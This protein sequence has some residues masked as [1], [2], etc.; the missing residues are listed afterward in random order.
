MMPPYPVTKPPKSV[1]IAILLTL[2]FGPIGLFYASVAGGF[3]MMFTKIFLALLFILALIQNSEFWLSW[4]LLLIIGASILWLANIIW[5]VI[6]V[7]DYNR[8]IEYDAKRQF[9]LWN[10]LQNTNMAPSQFVVN[11]N[12]R[13]TSMNTSGQDTIEVSTKPNLQNWLKSNPGKTINDYFSKFGK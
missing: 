1:G 13:P 9:E 2:L 8:K 7:T 3:I 11:V 5:A 4:S 10:S 6:S 12:P